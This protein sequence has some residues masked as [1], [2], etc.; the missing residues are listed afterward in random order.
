MTP[1]ARRLP[2]HHVSIRV[3]W[4]DS[5]WTGTVCAKP[6]LNVACQTLARVAT[7]KDDQ[8][9]AEIAGC[10]FE[11]LPSNQHPPCVHER[12]MFM[13]PTALSQDKEHP[14]A[15]GNPELYSHFRSTPYTHAPYSA[16]CIPFRWMLRRN[17]EE[18]CEQHGMVFQ[19]DREPQLGF[20]TNWIQERSNQL[21]ILDTF[22]SAIQPEASLCFFYAKDTPLSTSGR[23][24]II[25][26]GR[27]RSVS[28]HVE[29]AYEPR[30]HNGL[31]CV[32]WERNVSHSIRPGFEDGFVFPY[33]ELLELA[34]ERGLDP[35]E[36]VAYAPDDAFDSFSYVSELV[37]HD[38]AIASI[39]S[40][41]RALE[42]IREVLDGPWSTVRN[43]LDSQLSSLWRLRGPF[44]GF[45]SAL[46]TLLGP[47][48]NLVA[49]E[50]A[51]KATKDAGSGMVD[52]W[53]A[54]LKLMRAPDLGEGLSSE[55]VG[56][57]HARTWLH[58]PATR[59]SLLKLL[60]RFSL[61]PEQTARF[62]EPDHR[63][64]GISDE[65]LLANPYLLYELDRGSLDS[66]TVQ[67][68]D[69]GVL[70]SKAVQEA[71]PLPEQSRL[72]DS[73]DWRRV[74]SMMVAAL[75]AATDEGHTLLPR[76]WVTQRIEKMP[77][78]TPCPANMD[79][80]QGM[81]ELLEPVV[82]NVAMEDESTA[83][84]LSRFEETR[85][86]VQRAVNKRVFRAKRH[87]ANID[88]R[89]RVDDLFK[90]MPSEPQERAIEDKARQEKAAALKE[91]HASRLSVL[92]GPAGTGKT[93]LLRMLCDLEDVAAGG[94]LLLA[95]TGKA[96]VQLEQKTKQVGNGQTLAQFLMRTGQRYDP[97][98][99]RYLVTR[100]PSRCSDYKTVIIDECSMLTEE[101]L[102]A[103]LDALGSVQRLVL[104]GDHRQLPPIGS[105]RPFVDI[106][107][108]LAPDGIETRFPRV[109]RG[110]AELTIHRRQKGRARADLLLASWFGGNPDPAADEVWDLLAGKP[111]EEIQFLPWATGEELHRVLLEVLQNELGLSGLDDE[112]GFELSYLSVDSKAFRDKVYFGRSRDP[113]KP[114]RAEAWQIISPVRAGEPGVESINRLV[115]QTFRRGWLES[116]TKQVRWRKL[117]PPQG[118]HGIIYGDKVI[119][120]ENS[121]RR[122]VW[123]ER[124]SYVANGDVGLVVGNYRGGG[125]KKLFKKLEVEFTS[126]P[127]FLYSYRTK[128]FGDE[129]G[130]P[131]ELA[132][133]LTVHKTQGSEFGTT[134]VV[135]PN[136]CWLLSR[137]LLYT[138]LTR[139]SD[140]VVVL[141]Q[142]DLRELRRYSGETY[143]DI[144]RRLT[145]LFEAPSPVE[146]EVAGK[147]RFL[148]EGLIHRTKRGELVRSK[149]EV[150]IA[151]E[152]LAQ[153]YDR[154]QYEQHLTLPSGNV[155][156]PDFTVEDEDT[157][158]HFYWEHLGMLTNPEYRARWERK[159][160]AY[161]AAGIVPHDEGGGETGTLIITR[162]DERGG[163]DAKRIAEIIAEV[164][165][166]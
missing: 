126:Q 1:N 40:C 18:L 83:Y 151:N 39:L 132:Y 8:A 53:P 128:E 74:R 114:H 148:E 100:S 108:K 110:Y 76:A 90:A 33:A 82:M 61:S 55:V 81:G 141:H 11:D 103:T 134:I 146:I 22:F 44:P 111:L 142:G 144:A 131:L 98:T 71:F 60:S 129:G 143:S 66:I 50:L 15:E 115:Q 155:R 6:S 69:R 72:S 157:G 94:L 112:Q 163:I 127:R 21:A 77:L 92:I 149:S 162:D 133:A 65:D 120:L 25:G 150:I 123:P 96:R 73:V 67:T 84:Q 89:A 160:A 93:T 80:L 154:Y 57:G 116:A 17:A 35:E 12:A 29:Y 32:L 9:E 88:W 20:D 10:R 124:Q 42:A 95:P 47:G 34:Q 106:V 130:N 104:V 156:Y 64:G 158:E 2:T 16:A 7:A 137:E 31:R 58:M 24:V 165:G 121:S 68:I 45:G 48:G 63:P 164:L 138:A 59:K 46:S 75:E 3:P 125:R 49:Y 79:V 139:Q 13:S 85:A 119:N 109:D 107:R 62:F 23:R 37:D 101:Q 27:V 14:Y 86:L 153:G 97:E 159:L 43:W 78:D 147:P 122:H 135:I 70:P 102:A 161:R 91:L 166:G 4:H 105:G 51:A 152:L 118:R 36:F 117:N 26:V 145:N 140:R 136:P 54:F 56:D 30:D 5:G 38:S 19:Q 52:P 87:E 41:V 28:P 99:G 113:E